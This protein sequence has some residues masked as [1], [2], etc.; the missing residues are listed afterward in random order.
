MYLLKLYRC[1]E[2]GAVLIRQRLSNLFALSSS[3]LWFSY[4]CQVI[5]QCKFMLYSMLRYD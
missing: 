5:H 4:P 3:N 2:T 1:R